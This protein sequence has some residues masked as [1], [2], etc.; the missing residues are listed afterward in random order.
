MWG[1]PEFPAAIAALI[2]LAPP[3]R[4]GEATTSDFKAQFN[5]TA[6]MRQTYPVIGFPENRFLNHHLGRR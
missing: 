3:S 5:I 6:R 4:I 1:A 2:D